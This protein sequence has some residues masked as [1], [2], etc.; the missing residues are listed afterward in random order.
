MGSPEKFSNNCF[1][2]GIVRPLNNLFIFYSY[3]VKK[4]MGMNTQ[5]FIQSR[6][7]N[8]IVDD[9]FLTY[10]VGLC[11]KKNHFINAEELILRALLWLF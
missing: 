2:N 3:W 7:A 11:L 8:S 6:K 1:E 10:S 4:S 9:Q 5:V